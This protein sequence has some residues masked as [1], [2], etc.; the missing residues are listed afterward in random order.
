MRI[1]V[2]LIEHIGDIV[3][4]EPVARYVKLKYPDCELTWAVS[5]AYREL[6]DSNPNIDKTLTVEC[7]TDWARLSSHSKHDLVF[8]LHVNY[9]VCPHCRIPLTKRHGNPFVSAFEWFD[10]GGILEAFSVGAGLPRLSAQPKLYLT[11]EHAAAVDALG[12]PRAFC[13]IHRESNDREKDW[14]SEHWALLAK[15]LREE[16]QLPIVEVGA[17]VSREP[18]PLGPETIDLVNRLPI[19]QTAEVIRRANFFVGVDSAPGHLANALR[20]PGVV[21]LGRYGYFR[22]YNP[23]TGFYASDAPE[24][25]LVRNLTGP[26]RLLPL[27]DVIEAVRYIVGVNPTRGVAEPKSELAIEPG[28]VAPEPERGRLLASNLFDPAW[29]VLHNPDVLE[30]GLSPVDHYLL[31]GSPQNREPSADFS[32]AAYR[33]DHPDVSAAGLDP[34][35]HYLWFGSLE[36]RRR[37]PAFT[38]PE[39]S[40]RLDVLRNEQPGQPVSAQLGIVSPK[41]AERAGSP[42]VLPRTFAFYLPQFHPIPEN[43]WAHGPGFTEWH[44]VIKATPLFRDHYQPRIPGELGF[45]DLRSVEVLRA[46][47]SLAQE[48]GIDGFCFY[49][50]YFQGKRLLYKPLDNYIYSNMKAPFFV[51]WANENWSKRWDGGDQEVIVAQ[52]HSREDDLAF[53]RETAQLFRDDRYVKIK[54]KPILM[55]YKAH[56]FPDIKATVEVWREEIVRLGFPGL[57]LVMVDDWIPN[58]V[59]P[60]DLGFDAAY[61]IPSILVPDQVLARGT[62]KPEVGPTFEGRIVDYR[63]FAS[64]H[65]ARPW[66]Q[67]KRFRTVMLPWDNTARYGAKA[68]VHINGENEAYRLW[69]L[70]A[71]L[72][73]YERY[74]PEERIVF[75]H[76][77]NE[78]CEGTYL[79]PDERLGRFFLEQTREAITTAREVIGGFESGNPCLASEVIRMHRMKDEAAFQVIQAARMHSAY[80]WNEAERRRERIL[81]LESQ[82]ARLSQAEARADAFVKS[83]SWRLTAPVRA[84]G[85]LLRGHR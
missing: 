11:D 26:A 62:A 42:A 22:K 64:F 60:R 74:E 25:K 85:R 16:F 72:G 81:Q 18:S 41:P 33:K 19:L 27:A 15:V 65:A 35:G 70:Q 29:Y 61:E 46:Q 54:G 55:I 3:A 47:L 56:L 9:R 32:A 78:W 43:D 83:T 82:V 68:M 36:A 17:G 79:E 52:Q 50:Y 63:K 38:E 12:L 67:Y 7:L 53:I 34:L 71:L 57:Y 14:Q 49:Y 4:C 37:A 66:P 44:N 8:D 39:G 6:V 59:H 28:T 31:V 40:A 80:V 73:T 10:Y 75:L 76:S 77:W 21:L 58:L 23:F 24:V 51:L 20:I 1:L 48:H 2:G 5:R 84:L 13:V 45:Y 30:S 69:L